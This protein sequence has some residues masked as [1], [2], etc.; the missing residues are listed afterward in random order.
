L[1]QARLFLTC[2]VFL[3]VASLSASAQSSHAYPFRASNYEIEALLQPNDQTINV[4][5]RIVFI[6]NEVSRNVLV[7]LHQDLHVQSVKITNGPNLNFE[8]DEHSPIL[9]NVGLP[10][11][12]APGKSIS[13]TFQY[14]GPVSNEDDSP[15]KG[16]R[17]ASVDKTSAY[18]LQPARWFP[19]TDYPANRYTGTFKV[20]VPDTFVVVGTGKADPPAMMPGIGHGQPSQAAYVFH[21]DKAGPVGTFVAGAL[22]LSSQQSEGLPI[23][24]YTPPAQAS[25]AAAYASSLTRILSFYDETFGPLAEPPNQP[26]ITIAQMP[27]GSLSGFSAP[28]LVLISA[29]EWG[30]K[31]NEQ[32]LAEMAA[33]QWW[34]NR[35]MPA[36]LADEWLSDGL[37][38]YASAM[39]AEESEGV[40]G[41]H[42]A[43]EGFAVG[44]L[45]FDDT[46]PISQSQHVDQFNERYRSI[47]LDKGAM[48]YH[49]LRSEI[50]DDA[51]TS[52]LAEFYKQHSGKNVTLADFQKLAAAK[53]PPPAK[54]DPPLNLAAFFSQW[55][56]STGVPEFKMDYIVYRT[57]KGFKVVGRIKQDLD[58]L[59]MP[60]EIR[61]ETEGNPETKKI[62]VTGTSTQ[63][64]I[65]TFGRPKPNGVAIDPN[66]NLLKSSPKLRVRALVARGEGLAQMGKYYDAIQDYQRAL[67]LQSNSSLALFRTGEAMFYEKNYNAAA[68]SF[69]AA[70]GGDLDPKWIEVWSHIYIGEIY[71]LS[72]QRARAVNE[73]QLAQHLNDNTAGAQQVAA[74]YLQKPY[75]GDNPPPP[76][77]AST[78]T[79]T[80]GQGSSTN[81]PAASPA[82]GDSGSD[83]PVLKKRPE[84]SP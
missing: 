48:V 5:A 72:G 11:V 39:Y 9:L 10:E 44:A 27:D 7:E 21:C 71:D 45:M 31:P 22:Q 78:S 64:E 4:E 23:P 84:N 83:K 30:P 16:I 79:S 55:L 17:L 76:S 20:V 59:R 70:L 66:N 14:S 61:V 35:V 69:R 50:G 24:V 43:L 15:S 37:A 68:N 19:L 58:L 6:A 46:I 34:N 33:G 25:T 63:F 62:L 29:R 26:N 54:G 8:R 67:D 65:D 12:L 1:F 3:T 2:F 74:I 60:V 18:L 40:A 80:T 77:S 53:V 52:L 32:L 28:G 49:M 47:V 81:P 41:L 56:N 57:P 51:F 38:S 73:Y 75:A 42:K 36:S 13:L 82:S